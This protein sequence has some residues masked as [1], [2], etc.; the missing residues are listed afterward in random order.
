MTAVGKIPHDDPHMHQSI[1]EEDQAPRGRRP[2]RGERQQES[3]DQAADD[4]PRRPP[5]FDDAVSGRVVVFEI[6][7]RKRV[8]DAS[9]EADHR[10]DDVFLG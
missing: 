6:L 1:R 9:A 8:D 3:R 10:S 2:I 7:A 4:D 5:A